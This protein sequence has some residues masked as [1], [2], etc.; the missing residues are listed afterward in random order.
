MQIEPEFV[1]RNIVDGDKVLCKSL[2]SR[3]INNELQAAVDEYSANKGTLRDDELESIYDIHQKLSGKTYIK[4]TT[5]QSKKAKI[6]L[7]KLLGTVD[8]EEALKQYQQYINIQKIN[9]HIKKTWDCCGDFLLSNNFIDEEMN[10]TILGRVATTMCDGYPMARAKTL[11]SPVLKGSN[12]AEVAA[13]L[14]LFVP[15]AFDIHI[16]EGGVGDI[17]GR[18]LSEPSRKLYDLQSTVSEEVL[19]LYG[20]VEVN[21]SASVLVYDWVLNKDIRMVTRY[22]HID[23]LGTFVKLVLRVSSFMDEMKTHLLGLEDYGMYNTLEN[24]QQNLFS[25]IV[26]N[27]SIYVV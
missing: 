23:S 1:L 2:L 25:G 3:D 18:K 12:I 26:C 6:D 24:H 20:N 14:A 16:E 7:K 9:G 5:K 21:V 17:F 15:G 13:Y 22:A 10:R 4:Y 19:F 8:V 27:E 11:M